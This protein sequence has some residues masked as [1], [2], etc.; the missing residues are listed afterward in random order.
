MRGYL[1]DPLNLKTKTVADLLQAVDEFAVGLIET[2]QALL[3]SLFALLK[4]AAAG[5]TGLLTAKLD[6]GPINA[7]W[8]VLAVAAGHEEDGELTLSSMFSLLAAVPVT[9]AYKLLKGSSDAQL[10]P[11][12]AETFTYD[13]RLADEA[14]VKGC[15]AAAGLMT[16]VMVPVNIAADVLGE[17]APGWLK[18]CTF[19]FAVLGFALAHAEL[20]WSAVSGA[21]ATGLAAFGGVVLFGVGAIVYFWQS[22]SGQWDMY[23]HLMPFLKTLLGAI[24][25]LWAVSSILA[26][27]IAGEAAWAGVLG[28]LSLLLAFLVFD[29]IRDFTGGASTAAKCFFGGIGDTVSGGLN[30]L[31]NI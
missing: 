16:V 14:A 30:F 1:Q 10:F 28:S 25:L 8:K 19:G 20:A 21:G 15:R 26:G 6:L 11:K 17:E 12:G 3:D 4:E 9:I 27:D 29:E 5:L 13:G 31:R 23:G 18:K 24:S 7:L 22:L 2:A